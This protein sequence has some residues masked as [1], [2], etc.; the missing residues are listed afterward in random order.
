MNSST[1][2]KQ[3]IKTGK[4]NVAKTRLNKS[5]TKLKNKIDPS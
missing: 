5:K 1:S 2:K 4:Q 3:K